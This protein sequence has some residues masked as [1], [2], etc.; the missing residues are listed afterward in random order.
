M[1][2]I[3][4]KLLQIRTRK[5]VTLMLVII[6]YKTLP[7]DFNYFSEIIRFQIVAYYKLRISDTF[8]Y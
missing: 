4:L 5:L 6:R 1:T 3:I 7:V 8:E 2:V